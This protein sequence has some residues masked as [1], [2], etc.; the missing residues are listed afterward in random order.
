MPSKVKIHP[1]S[2][3]IPSEAFLELHPELEEFIEVNPG[4]LPGVSTYCTPILC[5]PRPCFPL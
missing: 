1:A 2:V 5:V 3:P 4:V